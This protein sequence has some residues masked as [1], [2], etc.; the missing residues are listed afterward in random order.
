MFAYPDVAAR[1]DTRIFEKPGRRGGRGRFCVSFSTGKQETQ[2]RP[3][4][5]SDNIIK[6]SGFMLQ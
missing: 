2:N 4:R 5:L 3:L 6:K 1:P